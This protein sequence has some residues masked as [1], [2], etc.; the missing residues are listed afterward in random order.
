MN[1]KFQSFLEQM[2]A[3]GQLS[4]DDF[5]E[6]LG[7][8]QQQPQ[9]LSGINMKMPTMSS[10]L[11]A[12]AGPAPMPMGA[13]NDLSFPLP[14]P[15]TP[16]APASMIPVMPQALQ[17]IR[18]SGSNWYGPLGVAANMSNRMQMQ[19]NGIDSLPPQQRAL[20]MPQSAPTDVITPLPAKNQPVEETDDLGKKLA[21]KMNKRR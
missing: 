21:N 17:G 18:P 20:G 1:P 3:N 2:R 16:Q 9:N 8:N 4:D 15:Q 11:A 13:P 6:F 19:R 12:P 14:I 10:P 5:N 7:L